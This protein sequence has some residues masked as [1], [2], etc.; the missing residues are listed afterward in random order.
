ME[1]F[2]S[3]VDDRIKNRRFCQAEI[4]KEFSASGNLK[5]QEIKVQSIH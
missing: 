3:N 5:E 1:T 4:N 2:L